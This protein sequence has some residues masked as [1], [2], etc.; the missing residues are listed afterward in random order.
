M[1][2]LAGSSVAD[3][4]LEL[5]GRCA[6]QDNYAVCVVWIMWR[7]SVVHAVGESFVVLELGG[8][9][10]QHLL[11]KEQPLRARYDHVFVLRQRVCGIANLFHLVVY[12]RRLRRMKLETRPRL[13]AAKRR[14]I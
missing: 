1:M 9:P 10:C 14:L 8:R 11:L 13:N 3:C 7:K 12:P 5:E 2:H 6:G 4:Q